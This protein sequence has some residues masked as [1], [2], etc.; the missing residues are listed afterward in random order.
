MYLDLPEK[1]W[2]VR[3]S[4]DANGDTEESY[5][6]RSAEQAA[7]KYVESWDD[8]RLVVADGTRNEDVIVTNPERTVAYRL[9]VEGKLIP[10][11]TATVTEHL[12]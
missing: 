10:I 5:M 4:D 11:Y 7:E 2:F 9:R 6:A 12:S 3:H 1:L 8:S